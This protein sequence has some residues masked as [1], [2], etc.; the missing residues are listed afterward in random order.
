MALPLP[1]PFRTLCER[2]SQRLLKVALYKKS[3]REYRRNGKFRDED[4]ACSDK[5]EVRRK[6]ICS[7]KQN[8]MAGM[9]FGGRPA[10]R[11]YPVSER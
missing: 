11:K 7:G 10:Q 8:D 6:N 4:D 9:D 5:E 3:Q 1:Y 2:L